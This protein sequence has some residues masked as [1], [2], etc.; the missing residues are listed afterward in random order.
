M[1]RTRLALEKQ[2]DKRKAEK[3]IQIYRKTGKKGIKKITIK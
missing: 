3:K 1:N 2:R